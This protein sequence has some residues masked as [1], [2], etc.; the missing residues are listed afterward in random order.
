MQNYF[1]TVKLLKDLDFI[2]GK[3][4]SQNRKARHEGKDH[5]LLSEGMSCADVQLL[6]TTYWKMSTLL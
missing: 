3:A 5:H 2:V 4:L 1:E 6:W